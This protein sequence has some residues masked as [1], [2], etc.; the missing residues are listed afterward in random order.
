MSLKSG[1]GQERNMLRSQ[2]DATQIISRA[3]I[4]NLTDEFNP[5]GAVKN[6]RISQC[7]CETK[8]RFKEMGRNLH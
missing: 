5:F 1:K 6:N 4:K 8:H 7:T 2:D 3:L